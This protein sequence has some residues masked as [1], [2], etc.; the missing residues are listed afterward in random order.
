MTIFSVVDYINSFLEIPSVF[1]FFGVSL[2]LSVRTGF[3]Q[4]MGIPRL[5]SL[6]FSGVN[7]SKTSEKKEGMTTFQALF[8]AMGTTIGIGNVV[9]PSLA[10][11]IGGPGA[12]F[13]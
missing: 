12:L 2:I 8:T 3:V 9:S 1:L 4:I 6:V 7:R 11:V 5:M 13:W 10:I